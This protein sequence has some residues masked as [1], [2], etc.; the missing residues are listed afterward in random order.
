[1]GCVDIVKLDVSGIDL[2]LG[3]VIVY[4]D[5]LCSVV[6]D[7]VI[8]KIIEDWLLVKMG[9]GIKLCLKSWP[10]LMIQIPSAEVNDPA[11]SFNSIV[12]IE[13]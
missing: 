3:V 2:V 13:I 7:F 10:S 12:D 11:V 6:V 8:G 5:M 9:M 1:M 4:V